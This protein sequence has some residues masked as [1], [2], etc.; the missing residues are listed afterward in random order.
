MSALFTPL[1]LRSVILPN[2]V[3][4][5]PMCQYMAKDGVAQPWHMVHLGSR[6][7]GG[8]GLVIAEATGVEPR[9]RI[10]PGCLGLWSAAQ[11][12][13]LKPVTDFIKS[14]G[15]VPA[16]QLA[17]AGRKGARHLPWEGNSPLPASESWEVI[18]P[19]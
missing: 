17:H 11:A 18:S 6:A 10:T 15:A 8:A 13:A 16:I 9:G 12:D 4:V 5:S 2:R 19:S 7:V 14:Q 3:A 1:S